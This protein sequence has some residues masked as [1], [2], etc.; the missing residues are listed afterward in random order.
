MLDSVRDLSNQLK[1]K[2]AIIDNFIPRAEAS[3][4][5]QRA[6]WDEEVQI[7]RVSKRTK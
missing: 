1:L 5:E 2:M 4:L 6:S 3:R 7:W